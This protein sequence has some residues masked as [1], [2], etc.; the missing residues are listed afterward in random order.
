L[1]APVREELLHFFN[2]N[3]D[4]ATKI[5]EKVTDTQQLRKELQEVKKLARASPPA[6][7]Q[8]DWRG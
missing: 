3:K 4:I 6:P 5:V 2:R 8:S 7:L 1:T